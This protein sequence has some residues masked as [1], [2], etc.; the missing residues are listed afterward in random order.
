MHN[1][2]KIE[3]V[4]KP[5]N[6]AISID[7]DKSLSIRWAL[8]ASQASGKSKAYKLLKSEDVLNT[9]NCLKKLGVK[10]IIKK[11]YCE[12]IGKGL[13]GF[14]YKKDLILNVGNSGTLG[15]LILGL[16]IHSD[17]K[18]KLIGDKSLSKRDF[19]RV[20]LPL[21][22]FG[23]KFFSKNL[24]KLPLTIKG[25]KLPTPIRYIEDKG[26]AQCK[27]SV[28]LAALNT[29]GETIIKAK[30]SRNHT[31]LLFKHL[32][33]PIKIKNKRNYDLIKVK[34]GK[35][36]KSFNYTMPSDIS[37]SAF[38][39][40]L[41]ALSEKSK[42]IIRNTNVNP[43]RIGIIKIL[44]KMGV[45]ISL[46]NKK[47]YKGEKIADIFIKSSK[48]L[49][50]INCPANLNSSA[51]DEFLIIFLVAARSKGIS[52]F[53]DVSELNKKESPRLDWGSKI[54]NMMG[55]KTKLTKDSIKIYGQPNL[56]ITRPIIISNFLK[57][58]RVFMMSTIAALTCGGQWKIYDK[59]S[60]N[61]SFP[62]FLKIVKKING[63]SL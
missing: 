22:K 37:S 29:N 23:A 26:S 52:Y 11:K 7:G 34:G 45:N 24:N 51:I 2:I 21:K 46:K 27:S 28:M 36:F 41:T 35:E 9:L 47:D 40:V 5:F 58:H 59:D 20:V 44:R 1:F 62:S 14:K 16:L 15:R 54:L 12:I 43:S 31:E 39:I 18:I 17:K 55:V 8:L 33:I 32:K 49:K 10:V 25:L 3:K 13:N 56:K 19:S 63:K 38:F 48:N 42:L 53:K 57:D 50:A 61:T 60:I 4:I 6:K 30:K